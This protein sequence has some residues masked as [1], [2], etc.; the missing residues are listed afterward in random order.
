MFLHYNSLFV[1]FLFLF[2]YT[3]TSLFK[4]QCPWL[5]SSY[6]Y[7]YFFFISKT[8]QSFIGKLVEHWRKTGLA[9][10]MTLFLKTSN[11]G[12]ILSLLH[13]TLLGI[14]DISHEYHPYIYIS[15]YRDRYI[16]VHCLK[17]GLSIHEKRFCSL[18]NRDSNFLINYKL[19]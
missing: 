3:C 8:L 12:K 5:I 17:E 19:G 10:W 4:W 6:I 2:S 18:I 1:V 11:Y 16:N 13:Y 7:H 15:I 9:D 14:C